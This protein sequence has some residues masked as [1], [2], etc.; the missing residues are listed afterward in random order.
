MHQNRM[1]FES[2]HKMNQDIFMNCR[3]IITRFLFAT[4]LLACMLPAHSVKAQQAAFTDTTLLYEPA[5][6]GYTMFH[7]PALVIT[8]KGTVLAFT[9]GRYGKGKDWDDMD[10]LLRRSVNGGNTWEPSKVVIPYTKGKPTSNIT[11][12]ADKNGTVHVL[13]QVNYANAYY[14]KSTDE[15]KTW[16]APID[17]TYVFD[18]FKKDYD[19]KVLAP[20]P[21]HA[22]QMTNGRLLVPVWLCIPDRSK[23]GGDHRPSCVATIYSDD[24]GKTWKRGDIIS[25]NLDMPAN[26][27]DTIINPNESVVVQLTDGS[28]MINM[29]NESDS[30]RRLI[31]YSK[32][33]ISGWS[34]PAFDN[35]LFEPVCMASLIRVTGKGDDK[36]RLIFANPDSR[37]NQIQVRKNSRVNKPRENITARLSYDEGKTWPVHKVMHARGSGYSDLAVDKEGMI[38]CLYEIRDGDDTDWIYRMVIRRFNIEWL[39][40][41]KDFISKKK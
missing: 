35:D 20:G 15:G 24:N 11:P 21:A 23:P 10:L 13:F 5:V 27:N 39:T 14:I 12:I 31:S 22:I 32:N 16:S 3:I 1:F 17:I 8:E 28:I 6:G 26:S 36:P 18:L 25:N 19:W 41:G 2:G 4:F 38:F 29:R 37:N 30:N 40:D 33:G 34:K 9:E 7:V